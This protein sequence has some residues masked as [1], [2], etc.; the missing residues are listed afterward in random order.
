MESQAHVGADPAPKTRAR[1]EPAVVNEPLAGNEPLA[2]ERI[3]FFS[4]A[5]MAIAI[6]LL[7][8][9]LRIPDIPGATDSDF[10]RLL[11]DLA[12]RYLSF[13]ISF[14]VIAVYWHA[15]HRMFRF[16]VRWGG[17]LIAANLLFLF[18]V[19]QLPLLASIQ[20]TYGNLSTATALYATGL[21]LMGLASAAMWLYASRRGLLRDDLN[22]A[23]ERYVSIRSLLF[24]AIFA[25]SIVLALIAPLLAELTWFGVWI[26]ARRGLTEPPAYAGT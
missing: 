1:N 26:V 7:A 21:T 8:I 20:G 24:A 2:L 9:D 23:Y 14:V 10:L 5:V 16:V 18:F 22:P 11:G 13:L 19:V 4:D 17:G 12:P 3:V 25:V 6:T 15:H